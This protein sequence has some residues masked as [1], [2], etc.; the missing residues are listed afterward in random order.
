[1]NDSVENR[2]YAN[3]EEMGARQVQ[4]PRDRLRLVEEIFLEHDFDRILDVRCGGGAFT[5]QLADACEAA[6]VY[7]FEL[8]ETKLARARD[9]GIDA[10]SLD[11][12]NAAFPF[13]ADSIDAICAVDILEHL[14]DPDHFLEEVRRTLAPDGLFVLATPNLGSWHNRL[15]LLLGYQPFA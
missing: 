13:E 11:L 3:R 15:A 6:E 1:M 7:G 9:R 10:T 2:F 14:F 4:G 12:N 8:Y 5:E